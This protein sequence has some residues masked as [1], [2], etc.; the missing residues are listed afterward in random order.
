[1]ASNIEPKHEKEVAALLNN[2]KSLYLK[3]V[4]EL[5]CSFDL[6]MYGFGSKKALIEDFAST[7]LTKEILLAI[8]GYLH[9]SIEVL[10]DQLK[11]KK[12]A[13]SGN[14]SKFQQPFS[15]RSMDD[16]LAFMNES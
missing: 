10:L 13:T 6:L 4:F 9:A 5:R 11:A 12:A 16:V 3:W 8:N 15:S 7:T 2:Y 1:M 14:L